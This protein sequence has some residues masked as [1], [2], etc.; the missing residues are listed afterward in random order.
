MRPRKAKKTIKK[1]RNGVREEERNFMISIK[2]VLLSGKDKGEGTS[3]L[4]VWR[5]NQFILK[6]TYPE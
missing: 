1:E 2:A 5:S 4:C 6:E 3:S